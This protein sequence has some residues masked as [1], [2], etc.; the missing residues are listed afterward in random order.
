MVIHWCLDTDWCINPIKH[1]IFLYC[2]SVSTLLCIIVIF[3]RSFLSIPLN[4]NFSRKLLC[5]SIYTRCAWER[6]YRRGKTV[7][8]LGVPLRTLFFNGARQKVF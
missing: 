8:I 6:Y 1:S 4:P 2:K 7:K 3:N 5:L